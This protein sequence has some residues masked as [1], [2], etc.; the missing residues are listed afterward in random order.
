MTSIGIAQI[1]VY[2]AILILITK[3]LGTYMARLFEGQRTFLHP[4]VRP[5]ERL[6]YRL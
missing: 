6:C 1:A 3:P 4:L 2:F 5:L